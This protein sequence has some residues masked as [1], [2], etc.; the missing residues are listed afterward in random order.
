LDKIVTAR[1]HIVDPKT[2]DPRAG[3]QILRYSRIAIPLTS[4]LGSFPWYGFF[5]HGQHSSKSKSLVKLAEVRLLNDRINGRYCRA[6][7][8]NTKTEA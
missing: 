5:I 2:T 8:M 7:T 1:T 6:W 3:H 4:V